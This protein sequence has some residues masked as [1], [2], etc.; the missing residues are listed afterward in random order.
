M[1]E[2]N[3]MKKYKTLSI[4]LATICLLLIATNLYSISDIDWNKM[5]P[6]PVKTSYQTTVVSVQPICEV[7]DHPFRYIYTFSDLNNTKTWQ[8]IETTQWDGLV[9]RTELIY[10]KYFV[11]DIV[12]LNTE[13]GDI[14]S[15]QLVSVG[16]R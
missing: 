10:Q 14:E 11:G 8:Y 6:P 9:Y 2:E 16:D 5:F 15:I 12:Q 7:K 13:N 4:F 1:T 3:N